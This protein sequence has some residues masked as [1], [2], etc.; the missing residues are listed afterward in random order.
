MVEKRDI[1]TGFFMGFTIP[2]KRLIFCKV[3]KIHKSQQV[4]YTIATANLKA[5]VLKIILILC[6]TL[7][8]LCAA[9]TQRFKLP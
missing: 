4:R 2:N 9:I 3:A 8:F 1:F 5:L 7:L 6:R